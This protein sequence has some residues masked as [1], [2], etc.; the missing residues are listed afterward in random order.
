MSEP[1]RKKRSVYVV[2]D[3]IDGIPEF[4]R[5]YSERDA[6]DQYASTVGGNH[7]VIRKEL[8]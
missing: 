7:Q 8:L 5:V 1:G 4:I 3:W 2:V 6:A